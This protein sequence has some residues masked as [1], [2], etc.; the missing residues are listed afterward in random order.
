[1]MPKDGSAP[2]TAFGKSNSVINLLIGTW[3]SLLLSSFRFGAMPDF[4][5]DHYGFRAVVESGDPPDH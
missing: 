4:A 1:M 3:R 5:T 2:L